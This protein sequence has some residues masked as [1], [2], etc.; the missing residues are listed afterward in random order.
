LRD[1]LVVGIGNPLLRDEGVGVHV[2]NRLQEMD[3]PPG[4]EVVD[5]GT[6]SYDL[7]D[8]FCQSGRIIIVDAMKAGGQPGIIYRA[9]LKE[10][11]LK[12][13]ENAVS[14]HQMHFIEAMHMVNL[15]GHYPETLV[16]GVEPD[17]IDWGT[18]L[19][20]EVERSLPRVVDLVRQE[21]DRMLKDD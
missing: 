20:P 4:V 21:I 1:L 3:L 11:G 8:F 18:E 6:N 5:G 12:P 17:I 16:F 7:V 10:L 13:E 9:P 19:S 2:V 14:I 15:L